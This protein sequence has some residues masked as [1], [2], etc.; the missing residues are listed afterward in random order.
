[1]KAVRRSFSGGRPQRSLRATARQASESVHAESGLA[2]LS[3][4]SLRFCGRL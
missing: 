3:P 1:M 4:S 2:T